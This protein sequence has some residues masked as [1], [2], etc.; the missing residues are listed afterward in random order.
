MWQPKY[1]ILLLSARIFLQQ[2]T[3]G[4]GLKLAAEEIIC[5][6]RKRLFLH[7]ELVKELIQSVGEKFSY[8]GIR[9]QAFR[10]LWYFSTKTSELVEFHLLIILPENYHFWRKVIYSDCCVSSCSTAQVCTGAMKECHLLGLGLRWEI[11]F[12]TSW[13][14]HT[15]GSCAK[16]IVQL[17]DN[18]DSRSG[19][20]AI[21]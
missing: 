20:R 21:C 8:T 7:H 6:Y 14:A 4:I 18:A 11:C 1:Y 3:L 16:A 9:R 2:P 10:L 17:V 19:R 15:E 5:E 13:H 12:F